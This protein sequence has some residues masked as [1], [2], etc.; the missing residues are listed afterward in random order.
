MDARLT[1]AHVKLPPDLQT[2]LL[3]VARAG[4]MSFRGQHRALRLA[5]TIA[6][7]DG[8]DQIGRD[9]LAEAIGYRLGAAEAVAA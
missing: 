1:Q 8:R 6:D 7:L 9:D 5:R 3:T 4:S 2:M